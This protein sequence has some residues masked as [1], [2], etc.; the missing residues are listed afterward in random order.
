MVNLQLQGGLTRIGL[1]R[2]RDLPEDVRLDVTSPFSW[3]RAGVPLG[4][5]WLSILLIVMLWVTTLY[6]LLVCAIAWYNNGGTLP[7]LPW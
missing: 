1:Y 4:R 2:L 3:S 6:W 7:P 5:G